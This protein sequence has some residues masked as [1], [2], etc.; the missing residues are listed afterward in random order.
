MTESERKLNHREIENYLSKQPVV[1]SKVPGQ[2][3]PGQEVTPTPRMR[4]H[5]DNAIYRSEPN[6]L[7]PAPQNLTPVRS[8]LY[9]QKDGS[10]NSTFRRNAKHILQ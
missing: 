3:N 8:E 10:N 9:L 4:S 5:R 2:R 7:R 1:T 6:L